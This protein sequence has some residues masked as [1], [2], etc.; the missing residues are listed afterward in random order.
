M[1]KNK[2][3]IYIESK[4]NFYLISLFGKF[5]E[6]RFYSEKSFKVESHKC[7]QGC[8]GNKAFR[9]LFQLDVFSE[10]LTRS[11]VKEQEDENLLNFRFIRLSEN[12]IN[13]NVFSHFKQCSERSFV[14]RAIFCKQTFQSSR[15]EAGGENFNCTS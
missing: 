7:H 5:S 4:Q 9:I 6:R 11:Y 15:P 3:K 8:L 2:K 12:E 13:S 14:R 10:Y 1:F